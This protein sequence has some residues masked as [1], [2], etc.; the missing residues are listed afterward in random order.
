MT[1][2]VVLVVKNLPVNTGDARDI[3]LISGLG[4]SPAE[5]NSNPLQY[6]LAWEISWTEKPSG[7]QSMGP[8]RVRH[9]WATEPTHMAKLWIT[10]SFN[11][12]LSSVDYLLSTVL[13]AGKRKVCSC[14]QR[15]PGTGEPG[16]LPSMGSHRVGHD[17]SNLAAAAAL[18][19][20]VIRYMRWMLER[21]LRCS[22]E[23]Q[24]RGE[25]R[26]E[27]QEEQWTPSGDTEWVS[28]IAAS[29][30]ICQVHVQPPVF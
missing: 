9:N 5:G 7:L 12:Y 17:W 30:K 24:D 29:L 8:Q 15:I 23:T 21:K 20:L 26:M 1:S 25:P 6:I 11:K 14:P 4:R 3:G 18:R 28:S 16:G 27:T 13:E 19:E 22:D 10:S 2:Q